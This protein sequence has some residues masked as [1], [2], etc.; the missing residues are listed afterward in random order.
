VGREG[1]KGGGGRSERCLICVVFWRVSTGRGEKEEK[2]KKGTCEK[3]GGKKRGREGKGRDKG[4]SRDLCPID[5]GLEMREKKRKI[6]QKRRGKSL[7]RQR[8]A[9]FCF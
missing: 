7:V 5:Q 9:R 6:V 3:R 1:R 2:K 4:G 8:T